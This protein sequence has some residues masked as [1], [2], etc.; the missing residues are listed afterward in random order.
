MR[1]SRNILMLLMEHT[2]RIA[3]RAHVAV[4]AI[5]NLLV[6]KGLVSEPEWDAAIARVQANN[7]VL[8][9]LDPDIREIMEQL[10]RDLQDG[11]HDA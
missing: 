5:R 4:G 11:E 7:E 8:F 2:D 1:P 9:A 3:D 10:R 6:S